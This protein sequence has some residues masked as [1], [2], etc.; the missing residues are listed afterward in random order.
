MNCCVSYR[1]IVIS[2]IPFTNLR[3]FGC[4][5]RC[6]LYSGGFPVEFISGLSN[7][8]FFLPH[9]HICPFLFFPQSL[10][11]TKIENIFYALMTFPWLRGLVTGL[12][13]G[14]TDSIQRQHMLDLGCKNG[15]CTGF[16]SNNI[17]FNEVSFCPVLHTE[18]NLHAV[19]IWKTSGLC[20]WQFRRTGKKVL[21]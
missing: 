5:R 16:P 3:N 2:G 10:N 4:T 1:I 6:G 12:S 15:T 17:G 9:T 19:C 11:D 7:A 14:D 20:S 18:I 8:S 13:P 21:T